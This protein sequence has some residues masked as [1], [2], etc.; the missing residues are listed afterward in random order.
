MLGNAVF[1]SV[2]GNDSANWRN[3]KTNREIIKNKR[4]EAVKFELDIDP[5]YCIAIYEDE[6]AD[7]C[8]YCIPNYCKKHKKPM[9]YDD[10][11]DANIRCPECLA[12]EEKQKAE[13]H[14]EQ[15]TILAIAVNLK[16]IEGQVKDKDALIERY[17]ALSVEIANHLK[18]QEHNDI[19]NREPIS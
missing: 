4:G 1:R 9:I 12:L 2:V 16:K 3:N 5:K 7:D 15:E 17:Y 10:K 13:Q 8:I 14:A 19:M 6:S 18:K 11:R